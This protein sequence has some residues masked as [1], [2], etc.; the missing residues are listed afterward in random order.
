VTVIVMIWSV[1][2]P[3][4]VK[5]AARRAKRGAVHTYS[6]H[7]EKAFN[8]FLENP[9]EER[10]NRY[11]WLV[12]QQRVIQRIGVWPLNWRQTLYLV[13]FSNALQVLICIHYVLMRFGLWQ[14][15]L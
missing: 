5:R 4:M 10:L 13:V 8:A 11:T 6:E 12:G 2:M 15:Y 1:G 7:I 14:R 3:V 9:S